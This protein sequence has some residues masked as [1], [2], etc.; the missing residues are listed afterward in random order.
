[1]ALLEPSR[2][3]AA[4]MLHVS[5]ARSGDH[6]RAPLQ[7]L[8]SA[9]AGRVCLDTASI[10]HYNVSDLQLLALHNRLCYSVLQW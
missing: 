5:Y 10:T 9:Q 4:F 1:M 3:V 8:R 7:L 6:D 2:P